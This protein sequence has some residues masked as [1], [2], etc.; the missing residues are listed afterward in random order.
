MTIFLT[1]I[2]VGLV[3]V[4][5]FEN[6]LLP[7]GIMI[8]DDK[9]VEFVVATIMELLTICVIPVALKLFRFKRISK[10]LTSA[11]ALSKW[12][13]IRLLMLCVPM[14]VNTVFYYMFMNVA[15]G[16]MGIIIFL[17]LFFVVPTKERCRSEIRTEA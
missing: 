9:S 5:L 12:G 15:F 3:I 8:S 1:A 4:V 10:L 14:I 11:E 6:D 7:C 17:C 13:T 2:A 16:Y